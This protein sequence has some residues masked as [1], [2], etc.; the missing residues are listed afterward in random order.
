MICPNCGTENMDSSK[1]CVGCGKNLV[2]PSIQNNTFEQSNTMNMQS[3]NYI[4]NNSNTYDNYRVNVSNDKMQYIFVILAVILKPFTTFKEEIEKFSSLKNSIIMSLIMSIF[5]TLVVLIQTMFNAIREVSYFSTD[6]SWNFDNLK[7][8]DYAQIIG[9]NFLVYLGIIV[10]IA[11]VYYIASLI[12]K[13]QTNFS[14]L[15]GI[16]AT[17]IS[18]FIICALIISPLVSLIYAPLSI[19]ISIIGG[20]YTIVIVYEMMN[21]EISL[22]GNAKFYLNLICLSILAISVYFLYTRVFMST[23]VLPSS[24]DSILDMFGY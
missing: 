8:L 22:E 18:P 14:K 12:A 15:L 13:K 9:R 24:V 10:A 16:S 20:C 17:A 7:S 4:N 3:Q 23:T 21:S 6:T 19:I 2:S 1:F 5:A 11:T